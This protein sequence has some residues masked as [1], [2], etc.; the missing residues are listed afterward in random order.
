MSI[1]HTLLKPTNIILSHID[2]Y[3]KNFGITD[4]ET[5]AILEVLPNHCFDFYDFLEDASDVCDV[6]IKIDVD[7][8]KIKFILGQSQSLES[9]LD[10]CKFNV[11]T[12]KSYTSTVYNLTCTSNAIISC[13]DLKSYIN[14]LVRSKTQT[15]R[16]YAICNDTI[17]IVTSVPS[18]KTYY[19]VDR[20]KPKTIQGAN[21]STKHKTRAVAMRKKTW[22][23]S[24]FGT[25]Q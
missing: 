15:N 3:K 13:N 21:K 23:H 17:T 6:Q 19:V 2:K 9:S 5:I 4:A 14:E 18:K 8:K 11:E 10:E 1:S 24:L 7:T 22:F 20:H 16:R 12:I 25:N